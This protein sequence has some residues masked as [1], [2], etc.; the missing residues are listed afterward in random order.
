[1][2]IPI[3]IPLLEKYKSSAYEAIDSEWISNHGKFVELSTNKLKNVLNAKN[4]I[5]MSNGT[6]ATHCLFISLKY[7]YP[8][9]T[10]IYVPNNCYV[11][12]YNCALMEYNIEN[13]EM[14][15]INKDTW[16]ICDD[17]E[18]LLSLEQNSAIMIVHNLGGIINVDK[19]KKIRPDIILVEDNCEGLFGKYNG[20]FSGTSES[21]LCSSVSFYGNK[22]I[23]TGEGG[24]FITNDDEIYNYIKKVYS[25]GMTSKRY[26]HDLV[27]YNY[28]M[29]NVQAAFLYDQ[30]NDID[31]IL[32]LKKKV[33]DNYINLLDEEI[34]NNKISLQ[35]IDENCERANWMFSIK[36]NNHTKTID[37][38]YDYFI[39][40]GFE[41]RPFFYTYYNHNHLKDIK[42][43]HDL[44]INDKLNTS[45]IMI[46]SF[47]VLSIEEQ[48][49]IVNGIKN[50]LKEM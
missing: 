9:I 27:S 20:V 14:M 46:P 49:F 7:K 36:I 6:V 23:T 32:D 40:Q 11:A 37:E 28:R 33:F 47:P 3:Y 17:E 34:K 2:I 16:N 30:L 35:S 29:N 8:N 15:K 38:V 44:T 22:S 26:I 24:A 21:L 4:V 25:Q 42:C 41:T 19:I 1:M 13:L 31:Y 50:F 45:I 48:I 39:K 10:K 18:Y 12:A 5:L 43:I